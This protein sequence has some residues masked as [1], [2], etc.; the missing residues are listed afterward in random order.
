LDF[1]LFHV[2]LHEPLSSVEA[3]YIPILPNLSNIPNH[4]FFTETVN[5]FAH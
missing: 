2:C 5:I 3:L 1:F 4:Y